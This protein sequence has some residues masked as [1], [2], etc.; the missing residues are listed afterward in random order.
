[1]CASA[2]TARG[3]TH[4]L[5]QNVSNWM[6]V[7]LGREGIMSDAQ[8]KGLVEKAKSKIGKMAGKAVG[9]RE[10]EHE[11]KLLS[12]PGKAQAEFGD[13]REDRKKTDFGRVWC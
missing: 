9:N 12:A 10:F 5:S 6:T 1:M 3:N 7:D 4:I 2:Q 13:H 11:G 8:I